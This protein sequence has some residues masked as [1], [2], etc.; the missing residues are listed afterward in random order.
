MVWGDLQVD[1]QFLPLKLKVSFAALSLLLRST[2][3]LSP[4]HLLTAILS[5]LFSFVPYL[6]S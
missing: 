3:Q 5:L 1:T 4:S 2:V 6:P